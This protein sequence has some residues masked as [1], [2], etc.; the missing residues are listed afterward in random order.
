[1]RS[2][3]TVCFLRYVN[4]LNSLQEGKLD[5]SKQINEREMNSVDK[6]AQDEGNG[7]LKIDVIFLQ[8]ML[9]FFNVQTENVI[10]G[11]TMSF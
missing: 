6:Q 10:T 7:D 5:Y 1:M 11:L 3:L 8:L 4:I 9:I 2:P